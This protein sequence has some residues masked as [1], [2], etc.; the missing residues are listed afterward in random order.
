MEAGGR[1][2]GGGE[3]WKNG[4]RMTAFGDLVVFGWGGK[5]GTGKASRDRWAYVGEG[6]EGL[7][8][9]D[10]DGLWWQMMGGEI[11]LHFGPLRPGRDWFFLW[12]A[13]LRRDT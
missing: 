4:G 9:I 6:I 8:T 2:G 12:D 1:G 13:R 5:K 10:C 11:V 3:N 7:N